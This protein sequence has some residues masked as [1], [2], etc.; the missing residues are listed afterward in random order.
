ML[1]SR[2]VWFSEHIDDLVLSSENKSWSSVW[3]PDKK[4]EMHKL[5]RLQRNFTSKREK[6]IMND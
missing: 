6:F 1:T 3:N 4:E 2:E 5:D